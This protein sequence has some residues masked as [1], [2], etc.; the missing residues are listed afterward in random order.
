M[1]LILEKP[2]IISPSLAA[3]LG[4]EQ[5]VLLQVLAEFRDHQ[6]HAS[7]G[8]IEIEEDQLMRF[9]PFWQL[10]DIERIARNLQDKGVI[11]IHS[12]PLSEDGLLR[13]TLEG[14]TPP[15]KPAPK[16][17][18]GK[19]V[20][21]RLLDNQWQPGED[22][23]RQL[24]QYNIPRSFA[25]Q[26]IPE[27]VTYWRERNEPSYSWDSKFIK[28]VLREWRQNESDTA[29]LQ[30]ETSMHAQWRPSQDAMEILTQQAG[31]SANFVEDAIP[32]FV[33]YWGERGE[34]S[35]TWNSK[36]INHVRHQ[37]ARYTSAMEN[38]AMPRPL[39]ENWQ[40]S[41]SLYEV[42]ALANISRAFAAQQVAEFVI[43]WC[44]NGQAYSSWN[45]RFL[46]HVK[47]QW[48]KHCHLQQ[49]ASH[50]RQPSTGQSV[51]TRD[52]SLEQDLSDR[53]WAQ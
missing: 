31:I 49:G 11:S 34:S 16:P 4:L 6:P 22:T 10:A 3:T 32:E 51:R 15:S 41:E 36:F 25:Q 9:L 7:V 2:L 48:A 46:Q 27:F 19:S 23:F 18:A 53:S 47:R 43:Y 12:A 20:G 39:P 40:P 30:R 50:E 28:R 42:L 37:W 1:S 17:M 52:R 8:L 29:R 33:L 13:L 14:E 45:T 24:A 35:N 21:T 44:E 38:D 5:A 26:L